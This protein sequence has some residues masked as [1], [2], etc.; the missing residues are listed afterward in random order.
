MARRVKPK[1]RFMATNSNSGEVVFTLEL[2][3]GRTRALAT[4]TTVFEGLL[5]ALGSKY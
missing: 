1:L 4:L 2:G 3:R 5:V